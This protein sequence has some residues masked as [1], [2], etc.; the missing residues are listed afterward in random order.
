MST[1]AR[2]ILTGISPVTSIV[3]YTYDLQHAA[4]HKT[5]KKWTSCCSRTKLVSLDIW[6]LASINRRPAKPADLKGD[7]P[8]ETTRKEPILDR[9]VAD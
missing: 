1:T 4:T 7:N 8:F 5:A 2:G 6:A 9:S 3:S